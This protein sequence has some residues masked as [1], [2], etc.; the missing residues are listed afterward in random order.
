MVKNNWDIVAQ[1]F[2][3]EKVIELKRLFAKLMVK[4]NEET[5]YIINDPNF[6]YEMQNHIGCILYAVN[7]WVF[8]VEVKQLIEQYKTDRVNEILPDKMQVAREL[9][10][11]S[12]K[13]IGV[14]DKIL[15]LQEYS[16]LMGYD[17]EEDVN[18][19]VA[20]QNVILLTD[21]GSNLNWE[22]KL[23]NNQVELQEK[24][25]KILGLDDEVKH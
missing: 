13:A 18:K 3:P 8:D 7:H 25:D 2:P 20:T 21:N 1:N 6:R 17:T 24:A 15:A 16:K 19:N 4:H 23:R 14:R 10:V 11:I 22:E 9:W 12:R 5:D